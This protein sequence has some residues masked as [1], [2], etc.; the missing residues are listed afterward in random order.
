MTRPI[1]DRCRV[2]HTIRG[3]GTFLVLCSREGERWA[4]MIENACDE[5][6]AKPGNSEARRAKRFRQPRP[7]NCE[8]GSGM[9]VLSHSRFCASCEA[10]NAAVAA[11]YAAAESLAKA[12]CYGHIPGSAWI[13]DRGCF[14][15]T[16]DKCGVLVAS[17]EEVAP[18]VD[19]TERARD[20]AKRG[21]P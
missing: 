3:D 20:A 11:V 8:C 5:F 18:F 13:N 16:K 15:T 19:L 6:H 14:A 10:Y 7:Y 12:R 21:A 2:T 9:P 4:P 1:C 17:P